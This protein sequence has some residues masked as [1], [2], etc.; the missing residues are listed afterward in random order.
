M[1]L[2]TF[3]LFFMISIRYVWALNITFPSPPTA[4]QNNTFLWTRKQGDPGTVLLRKQKLDGSIGAT[5]W[6][7]NPVQLD[8]SNPAGSAQINFDRAGLFNV[9]AFKTDA[10]TPISITQVAVSL[11]PTFAGA[12]IG[13]S[14][15]ESVSSPVGSSTQSPSVAFIVGLSLGLIA[16]LVIIGGII[17]YFRYRCRRIRTDTT[18]PS[19]TPFSDTSGYNIT[20][21]DIKERQRQMVGQKEHQVERQSR[22]YEQAPQ[23]SPAN[24]QTG[25]SGL[26]RLGDDTVLELRHQM[27][28]VTQRM[29]TLEAGMAPPP[30]YSSQL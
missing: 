10:T 17:L 24:N 21:T 7:S 30:D 28:I 18:P 9:G 29:A 13:T 25:D 1:L 4:G 22:S 27:A 23:T 8:L 14:S 16:L 3:L 12:S 5:P 6:S 2:A 11:I 15:T 26:N 19:L 20:R